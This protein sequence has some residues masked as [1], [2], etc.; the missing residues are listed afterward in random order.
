M[1]ESVF[2]NFGSQHLINLKIFNLCLPD[3]RVVLS[4]PNLKLVDVRNML[5]IKDLVVKSNRLQRI[6]CISDDYYYPNL[7]LFRNL[8]SLT[9]LYLDGMELDESVFEN[10]HGLADLHFIDCQLPAAWKNDESMNDKLVSF[11]MTNATCI[12]LELSF[13]EIKVDTQLATAL[14]SAFRQMAFHFLEDLT[15]PVIMNENGDEYQWVLWTTK[16]LKTITF[17]WLYGNRPKYEN[18]LFL[19]RNK[20]TATDVNIRGEFVFHFIADQ[21]FE[22]KRNKKYQFMYV[23]YSFFFCFCSISFFLALSHSGNEGDLMLK[24]FD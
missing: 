24:M 18:V 9:E 12:R 14:E 22:R 17:A 2:L 4:T 16:R 13:Y 10:P 5:E 11:F 7:K 20:L 19:L 21:F 15:I 1:M 8:P 6:V 23:N 3:G